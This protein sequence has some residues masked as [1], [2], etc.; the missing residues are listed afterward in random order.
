[1]SSTEIVVGYDGTAGS[2]AAL[3][4]A[5]RRAR[6]LVLPVRVVHATSGA[7]PTVAGHRGP[8]AVEADEPSVARDL[9]ADL[10]ARVARTAPELV[11]HIEVLRA[12]PGRGLADILAG[13]ETVVVGH[14][15]HGLMSE[16]ILGPTGAQLA[17]QATC[18]VVV[19]RPEEPAAAVGPEAGRVVVGL[20]G[21]PASLRALEFGIREACD[22]DAELTVV[23][24]SA[25]AV[26][27]TRE[28]IEAQTGSLAAPAGPVDGLRSVLGYL[29][30][31]DRA[32][33]EV[34]CRLVV[35]T[36]PAAAVLIEASAGARLVV[37]GSPSRAEGSARL[38]S[39]GHAVL[40]H[41]ECPVAVL[42]PL[43]SA[44]GT[45]PS[46]T[47]QQLTTAHEE[48]TLRRNHEGSSR[49]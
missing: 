30:G 3:G 34:Q 16:L 32:F 23:H 26:A 14:D 37:V 10:R 35:T 29:Q 9:M 40:Q 41:A 7:R 4:W 24:S 39:V 2:R 19:V 8:A 48:T 31:W 20:D 12:A 33:T 1:M 25:G 5:V 38:S 42:H 46:S 11:L 47:D 45:R 36:R 18:P 44:Q 6:R 27:P 13:A 22:Q 43:P 21:A 17:A 49:P 28:A 15:S